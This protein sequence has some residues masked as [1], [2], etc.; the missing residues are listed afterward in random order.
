M[1]FSPVD[2]AEDQVHRKLMKISTEFCSWA[3]PLPGHSETLDLEPENIWS[4][5]IRDITT[6]LLL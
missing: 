4:V 5:I 6:S 3:R 1:C 2:E